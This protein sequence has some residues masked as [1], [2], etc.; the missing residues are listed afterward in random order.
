M[1]VAAARGEVQLCAS[2]SQQHPVLRATPEE[3]EEEEEEACLPRECWGSC[4]H[5]QSQTREDLDPAGL[6]ASRPPQRY[7]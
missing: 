7:L 1:T 5:L 2:L 4:T 3:E 6:P